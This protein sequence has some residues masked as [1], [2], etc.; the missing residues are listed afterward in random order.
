MKLI[1]AIAFAML[2]PSISHADILTYRMTPDSPLREK[3]ITDEE[4]REIQNAVRTYFPG[5][6]V[7]V[8]GVFDR[9][10][11]EEGSN[12][13][14]QVIVNGR[15]DDENFSVSL[16]NF[17]DSWTVSNEWKKRHKIHELAERMRAR[18]DKNMEKQLREMVDG[19]YK[20]LTE[21]MGVR[22]NQP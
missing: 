15:V 14:S 17:G 20:N 2:A 13:I 3:N 10:K 9:C 16:S 7:Y 21:C 8:G 22:L 1:I 5:A 12:C 6:I 18:S 11:C 19:L 4:V